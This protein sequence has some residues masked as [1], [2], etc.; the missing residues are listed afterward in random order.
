VEI[1]GDGGQQAPGLGIILVRSGIRS[2]IGPL[3]A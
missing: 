1:G 2:K 3:G